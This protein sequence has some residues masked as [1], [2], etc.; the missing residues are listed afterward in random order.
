M[1]LNVRFVLAPGDSQPLAIAAPTN[2]ARYDASSGRPG[3]A[4]TT[5]KA[6]YF[7]FAM[8]RGQYDPW[9]PHSDLPLLKRDDDSTTSVRARC[10]VGN[11]THGAQIAAEVVV[12]CSRYSTAGLPPRLEEH[13]CF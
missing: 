10:P 8:P 7:P 5:N 4:A 12:C 9:G 6:P 13:L 2:K 11:A 3:L 1:F